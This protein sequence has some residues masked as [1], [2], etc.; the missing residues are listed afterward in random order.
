MLI[1]SLIMRNIRGILFLITAV[2]VLMVFE[3]LIE[4]KSYL[5]QSW[6][7]R[8]IILILI[9]QYTGL[10]LNIKVNSFILHLNVFDYILENSYSVR[11][12]REVYYK[13][14]SSKKVYVIYST[15]YA[16]ITILNALLFIYGVFVLFFPPDN[17]FVIYYVLCTLVIIHSFRTF[18]LWNS[19]DILVSDDIMYKIIK[20]K[21]IEGKL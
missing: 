3:Y 11:K 1:Y 4:N 13:S 5:F 9:Y 20:E 2:L 18:V 6:T 19:L 16:V 21:E 7:T 10:R 15:I 12:H 14:Y 17:L 8:I